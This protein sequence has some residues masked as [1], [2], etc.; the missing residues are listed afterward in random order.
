M[1]PAPRDIAGHVPP[2]RRQRLSISVAPRSFDILRALAQ[3]EDRSPAEM[4]R[5]L[6]EGA[7]LN[8]LRRG[9]IGSVLPFTR[10]DAG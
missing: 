6:L 8:R 10:K 3:E 1:A 7:L 4:A 2:R 5:I 9:P